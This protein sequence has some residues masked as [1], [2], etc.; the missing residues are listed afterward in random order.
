MN[1]IGAF[2]GQAWREI[3]IDSHTYLFNFPCNSQLLY[4]KSIRDGCREV[5]YAATLVLLRD[6][7]WDFICAI[8]SVPLNKLSLLLER[9]ATVWSWEQRRFV[10][11]PPASAG[12]VNVK[13]F[14]DILGMFRNLW[15][16][17]LKK[18]FGHFYSVIFCLIFQKNKYKWKRK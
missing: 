5:K 14:F 17:H 7:G 1:R 16:A 10:W 2:V 15:R 8:K 4:P 12:K 6:V 13:S 11:K 18:H 9:E 3:A